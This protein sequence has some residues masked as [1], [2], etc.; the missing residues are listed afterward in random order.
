MC[1]IILVIIYLLS[2]KAGISLHKQL[3]SRLFLNDLKE[4]KGALEKLIGDGTDKGLTIIC[5]NFG[6]YIDNINDQ[7]LS[8][9]L[10]VNS[11]KLISEI[12]SSMAGVPEYLKC[13]S[14][15]ARVVR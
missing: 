2:F 13:Y 3:A 4:L 11:S 7:T 1:K 15:K 5:N 10:F 12:R 14:A 9:P 8:D 6:H